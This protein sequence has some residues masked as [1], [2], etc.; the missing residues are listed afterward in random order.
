MYHG[1]TNHHVENGDIG[2][3]HHPTWSVVSRSDMTNTA[4]R[5]HSVPAR[6]RMALHDHCQEARVMV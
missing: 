3:P 1:L 5:I 4:N 6:K 2:N